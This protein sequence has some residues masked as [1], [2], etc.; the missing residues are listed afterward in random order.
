MDTRRI[1]SAGEIFAHGYG[2]MP[3]QWEYVF[4]HKETLIRFLSGYLDNNFS[5]M[6]PRDDVSFHSLED[7]CHA[8]MHPRLYELEEFNFFPFRSSLQIRQHRRFQNRCRFHSIGGVFESYFYYFREEFCQ[9]QGL[10]FGK[11]FDVVFDRLMEYRK[12]FKEWDDA[13]ETLL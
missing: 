9:E 13:M 5:F 10:W 6:N 2:F 8:C 11:A 1:I 3:S 12:R 7:D 4:E